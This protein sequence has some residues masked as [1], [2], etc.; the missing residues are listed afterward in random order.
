[1]EEAM[2]NLLNNQTA[3]QAN[4]IALTARSDERFA[5]I[6]S[7]LAEIR[8]IL[9]RHEQIL[10]RHEQILQALPETI[11]QKMGFEAR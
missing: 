8:A 4:F 2:A 5:R 6:E 3:F 9:A 1:L 10:L 7:E 11:R